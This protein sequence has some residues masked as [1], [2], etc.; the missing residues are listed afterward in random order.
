MY[1]VHVELTLLM[2]KPSSWGVKKQKNKK[3]HRPAKLTLLILSLLLSCFCRCPD[4]WYNTALLR[5]RLALKPG[6]RV[7][8]CT[9]SP[10]SSSAGRGVGEWGERKK[11]SRQSKSQHHRVRFQRSFCFTFTALSERTR[12]RKKHV[13]TRDDHVWLWCVS[14]TQVRPVA[15]C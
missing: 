15:L 11:K 12:G 6:G 9:S 7:T 13:Q 5:R 14:V 8:L 10:V 3:K 2:L 4:R 1:H